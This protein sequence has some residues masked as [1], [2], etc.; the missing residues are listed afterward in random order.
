MIAWVI[1]T[2]FGRVYQ[3]AIWSAQAMLALFLP[4]A[5]LWANCRQSHASPEKSGSMAPALQSLKTILL[6]IV[7]MTVWPLSVV[8]NGK[9]QP[10]SQERVVET[11]RR[12]VLERSA[13]RPDQVEVLLRS[14][15]PP[16]LP[17]GEVALTVLK[18]TRGVTPGL[19][20][21]LV[22]VHV[23]GREEVRL[24]VDRKSVV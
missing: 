3:G 2:D 20:R 16:T 7:L 4:K 23:N 15:S 17:E 11:V 22:A 21:F 19:R 14:F 5:V 8:A 12:Y 24:W 9:G 1:R 6:F 10:L 13:W 18:P